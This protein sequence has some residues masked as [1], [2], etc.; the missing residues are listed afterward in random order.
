MIG[1]ILV[2]SASTAKLHHGLDRLVTIDIGFFER[3]HAEPDSKVID[4]DPQ[5]PAALAQ[6]ISDGSDAI[7]DPTGRNVA[8]RDGCHAWSLCLPFLR[9]S[10]AAN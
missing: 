10:P 9:G 1:V 6:A 3:Q 7:V 8:Q 4:G 2:P 5:F